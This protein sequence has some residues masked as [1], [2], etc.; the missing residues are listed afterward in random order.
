MSFRGLFIF[1]FLATY[2]LV[3]QNKNLAIQDSIDSKLV[4]ASQ[5]KRLLDFDKAINLYNE[6]IQLA[7]SINSDVSTANAYTEIANIYYHQSLQQ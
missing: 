7:S 2:T 1:L 4:Q 3:G 6:I 5:T